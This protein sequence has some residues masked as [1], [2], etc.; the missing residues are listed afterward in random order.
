MECEDR[1]AT[2]WCITCDDPYCSSCYQR[3]HRKGKKAKHKSIEIS[4]D[5]AWV[6]DRYETQLEQARGQG[7]AHAAE[8]QHQHQR[9][10]YGGG[11]AGDADREWA[12]EAFG[13]YAG[14][15]GYD[16]NMQGQGYYGG[17]E[18]TDAQGG[19]Y[20][21]GSGY[22]QGGYGDASGYGV[23]AEAYLAGSEFQSSVFSDGVGGYAQEGDAGGSEWVQQVDEQGQSYY[24]NTIT[25]ESQW[26]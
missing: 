15:E 19:G 14:A 16:P 23:G 25:G 8:E 17:G 6:H 11:G 3:I 1:L 18:G 22:G 21:D 13:M 24:Y 9:Y 5:G 2:V 26:A 4:E 12:Q 20:G 7:A 10:G